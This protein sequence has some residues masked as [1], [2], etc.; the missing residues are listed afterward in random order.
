MAQRHGDAKVIVA[1]V[2]HLQPIPNVGIGLSALAICHQ[3]ACAWASAAVGGDEE[4]G[5]FEISSDTHS[6]PTNHRQEGK[7]QVMRQLQEVQRK[8][9]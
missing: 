9:L 4:N 8:Q 2:S 7:A 3:H 1:M 5:F 6:P